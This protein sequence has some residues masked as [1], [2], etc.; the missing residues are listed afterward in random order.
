MFWNKHNFS[1][2]QSMALYGRSMV[3][4]WWRRLHMHPTGD[5]PW[6]GSIVQLE[7]SMKV[8][9]I[10]TMADMAVAMGIYGIEQV[11]LW[12]QICTLW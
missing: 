7:P 8:N 5:D 1:L 9:N 11:F 2:K 4:E 6:A 10:N 3:V 12:L